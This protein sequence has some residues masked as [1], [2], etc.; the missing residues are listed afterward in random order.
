MA[1]P[2]SGGAWQTNSLLLQM[3]DEAGDSGT[4]EGTAQVTDTNGV[5]T[6]VANEGFVITF[7]DNHID[8]TT[9]QGAPG[10]QTLSVSNN[11]SNNSQETDTGTDS[12]SE[13]VIPGV[14]PGY[15]ALGGAAAGSQE[16]GVEQVN[17]TFG[18]SDFDQ[19]R[20]ALLRN[21]TYNGSAFN[22]TSLNL[23]VLAN[24]AFTD[25]DAG[26]GTLVESGGGE[27]DNE[28]GTY[29]D[30]DSGTDTETDTVTG[31][32]SG[33]IITTV[34]AVVD[35]FTDGDSLTDAFTLVTTNTLPSSGDNLGP[36]GSSGSGDAGSGITVTDTESSTVGE[37][38]NFGG[39][40]GLTVNAA[41]TYCRAHRGLNS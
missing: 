26:Q 34:S 27:S 5:G 9:Y 16:Q 15:P 14:T 32:A 30:S 39:S 23:N 25:Q 28:A 24:D 7:S 3:T 4:D 17:G 13:Q 41:W 29:Q 31:D 2:A 36:N 21:F 10:S 19:E 8:V 38:D 18:D 11:I 35:T 33:L 1:Q 6:S 40:E 12:D 22:L 20:I 37:Q